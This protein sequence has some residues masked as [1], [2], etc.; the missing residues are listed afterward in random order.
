MI[1]FMDFNV[2]GLFSKY[3]DYLLFFLEK[4]WHNEIP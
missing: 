1:Q 3:G 2:A 4:Q